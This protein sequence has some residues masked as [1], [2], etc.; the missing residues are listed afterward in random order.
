M[1]LVHCDWQYNYVSSEQ[2]NFDGYFWTTTRPHPLIH[3]IAMEKTDSSVL[4]FEFPFI[5]S[6]IQNNGEKTT[7]VCRALN[8]KNFLIH[9][10]AS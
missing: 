7:I 4:H 6:M 9:V 1:D 2:W 3:L 8:R 10:V 5:T